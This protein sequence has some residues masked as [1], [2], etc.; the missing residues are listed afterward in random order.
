MKLEPQHLSLKFKPMKKTKKVDAILNEY[1][2]EIHIAKEEMFE[3]HFSSE[4][5]KKYTDA[6]NE[7]SNYQQ[8]LKDEKPTQAKLPVVNEYKILK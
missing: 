8:K 6:V 4:T 1:L 7:L 3:E 2:L 5:I